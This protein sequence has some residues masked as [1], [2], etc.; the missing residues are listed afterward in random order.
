MFEIL[1]FS[2]NAFTVAT[3]MLTIPMLNALS[4]VRLFGEGLV[5][6]AGGRRMKSI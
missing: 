3:A 4:A 1:G 5:G 6:V 2:L